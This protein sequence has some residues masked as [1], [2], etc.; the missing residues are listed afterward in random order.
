MTDDRSAAQPYHFTPGQV[1]PHERVEGAVMRPLRGATPPSTKTD[2][3][4]KDL[5]DFIKLLEAEGELV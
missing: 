1:T 4:Y 3:R 5:R 2:L